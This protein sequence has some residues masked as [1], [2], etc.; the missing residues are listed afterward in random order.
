MVLPTSEYS[1]LFRKRVKQ[2]SSIFLM[3]HRTSFVTAIQDLAVQKITAKIVN[4]IVCVRCSILREIRPYDH[5]LS[6]HSRKRPILLVVKLPAVVYHRRQH[7]RTHLTMH[8]FSRR[9]ITTLTKHL[10][11]ISRYQILWQNTT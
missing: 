8:Q 3:V 10:N 1:D 7:S 4:G 11:C 5:G 2:N 9:R 6:C